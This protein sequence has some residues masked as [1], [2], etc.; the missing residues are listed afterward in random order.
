MPKRGR[1]AAERKQ[2]PHAKNKHNIFMRS[3]L[4]AI[5]Y[6]RTNVSHDFAGLGRYDDEVG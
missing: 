5:G 6:H 4:G 1:F 2:P 3:T